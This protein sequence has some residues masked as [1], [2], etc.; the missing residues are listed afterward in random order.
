MTEIVGAT[1]KD[2]SYIA[3]DYSQAIIRVALAQKGEKSEVEIF[4]HEV[5]HA[6]RAAGLFTEQE[7]AA[8]LEGARR[9]KARVRDV[10]KR[11]PHLL[12][13]ARLLEEVIGDQ[14]AARHKP[15]AT[16][17]A[18]QAF[19]KLANVIKAIAR[20]LRGAAYTNARQVIEDIEDGKIG[21]SK[22]LAVRHRP[23]PSREPK[24]RPA[25]DRSQPRANAWTHGK[26]AVGE[27][28]GAPA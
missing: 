18:G 5:I 16:T 8:L 27:R 13:E 12:D 20:A 28:A 7:W 23:P 6:M 1:G 15:T 21:R 14:F 19:R 11:Y 3:G 26:P 25:W 24:H 10:K 4:Y 22:N 2:G 9:S 17:L